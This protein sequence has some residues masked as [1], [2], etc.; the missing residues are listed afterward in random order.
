M[1]LSVLLQSYEIPQQPTLSNQS[2][3]ELN[4]A[5]LV[6]QM[7]N[8]IQRPEYRQVIVEL[9]CIVSIILSRNPELC[10]H[11]ILDLDQLVTEA[12]QMYF[13]VCLSIII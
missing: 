7:L 12:S 9:L 6:E 4:F 10:F 3:S 11:K 5:L 1:K 13:K 2:R 8:S